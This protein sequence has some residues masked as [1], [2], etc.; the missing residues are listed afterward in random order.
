[1]ENWFRFRIIPLTIAM[2]CLS[3]VVKFT[4]VMQGESHIEVLMAAN[5]VAEE[6]PEAE[7]E[8]QEEPAKAAEA[9]EEASEEKTE[10]AKAEEKP[11]QDKKDKKD[12]KEEEKPQ[13]APEDKFSE[14]CRFNQIEVDILQN[15][16]A[17]RQ[18]I[19]K[20]SEEVKMQENVLKAAEVQLNQKMQDL[21]SLREDVQAMLKKYEKKESG[22][23][24]S[25]VKIY[26]NMKPVD[27]ARIFN[28]M[29]MEI[30]LEVVDLM[31]ER[32]AAPI[33]ANMIPVKAK[34][35][36]IDLAEKRKLKNKALQ[37]VNEAE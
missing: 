16:S 11:K 22:E 27:A 8:K 36:T 32:K 5:A 12:K 14:K 18:E 21:Q 30:L 9:K 28:E 4:A 24:K 34:D 17:R 29:E 13:P 31:S 26:E 6:T 33:L 7:K 23:L 25:L 37:G 35:L 20:W 1:M 15:L 3:M 10:E 19:E 2:C